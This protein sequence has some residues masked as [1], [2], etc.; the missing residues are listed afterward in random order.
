MS[1]SLSAPK[2]DSIGIVYFLVQ[3]A[4]TLISWNA[5][6]NGLDYFSDRY[7]NQNVDFLLPLAFNLAQVIAN[8]FM[9][10]LST[11]FSLKYRIVA[12][13]IVT[14][15]VLVFLPFE[16][17]VFNGEVFGFWLVMGMLFIMGFC[18]CV[19]QGSVSGFASMFPFKY[20]SYFLMGTGLAGLV[21]NALRA[22]AI[23]GFSNVTGGALIEIVVYFGMAGLI[24][25]A[26]L[27]LHP[28]ICQ[29]ILLQL[30]P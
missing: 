8:F 29:I 16:A 14:S 2:S 22:L 20:T 5:V 6:L 10:A 30:L 19:Y 26:C 9:P 17:N 4:G 28:S 7:P 24:L 13:L 1:A 15:C 18:N 21:M 12:P 25:I 23:V 27:L 11:T 3:G